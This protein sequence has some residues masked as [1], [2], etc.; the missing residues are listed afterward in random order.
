[1]RTFLAVLGIA[2]ATPSF[3]GMSCRQIGT[4]T[5]CDGDD[6]S[7]YTGNRIGNTQYWNETTPSYRNSV[8]PTGRQSNSF[9]CRRIGTFTYC[10]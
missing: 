3:A 1:M 4:F 5:Y 9:S 8:P 10:D 7:S 6:G 2:L